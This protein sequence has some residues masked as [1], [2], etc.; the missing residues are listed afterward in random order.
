MTFIASNTFI[1]VCFHHCQVIPALR[2][3]QSIRPQPG[4]WPLLIAVSLMY[5][6]D[7]WLHSN[8]YF[9][10]LSPVLIF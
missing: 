1:A 10:S 4:L 8:Y 7:G 5:I 2:G 3:G 6:Y 9:Q